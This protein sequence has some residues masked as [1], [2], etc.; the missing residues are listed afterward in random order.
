M[1]GV[2]SLNNV[3]ATIFVLRTL[4][5]TGG[6]FPLVVMAS[7]FVVGI[8]LSI[9]NTITRGYGFFS[10]LGTMAVTLA[11]R[12]FI[13]AYAPT[14]KHRDEAF[15]KSSVVLP[16][17]AFGTFQAM[18]H[19]ILVPLSIA[20]GVRPFLMSTPSIP[21]ADAFRVSISM[22]LLSLTI[23]LRYIGVVSVSK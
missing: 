10:I 2:S 23:V 20:T 16:L 13:A 18:L 17:L 9:L 1:T 21:Y 12:A 19:L 22:F 14:S 6:L 4:I 15:R 3:V 5:V 7:P 8:L 11:G